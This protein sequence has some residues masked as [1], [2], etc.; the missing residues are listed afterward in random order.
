MKNDGLKRSVAAWAVLFIGLFLLAGC[1][2]NPALQ[3]DKTYQLTLM[4][5]NDQHGNFLPND[6][7]EYGLAAQE[8]LLDRYRGEVAAR[9]GYS[10]LLSAGDVNSGVPESSLQQAKP[11]FMGMRFLGY[12]AMVLGNHEF[13]VGREILRQQADW[14]GFP[15]LAANVF[16]KST[17]KHLFQDHIT[18]NFDGLN[19]VVFGLLTEDTLVVG[20]LEN[21]DNIEIRPAIETAAQIVP[22]LRK[23]AH[24]LIALTHMGYYPDG[25]YSINAPGDV[26]LARRVPGIDVIVGGHTHE[27]L[28]QPVVENGTLIVQAGEWGKYLGRLDLAYRNGNLNQINYRLTPVNLKKKVVK[29]GKKERV[30]IETKIPRDPGA[31]S[32]LAPFRESGRAELGRVI[33][34]VD[35]VLVGDRKIVRFKETNLANLI[36]R[37]IMEKT[38]ADVA[39]MNSGGIRDGIDAGDVTYRDVLTVLPFGNTLCTV[40]LNGAELYDYLAAVI[41]LPVDTGGFAQIAGVTARFENGIVSQLKINSEVLA[42]DR[43]YK[44]GINSFIASGAD[45][46]PRLKDHPSFYDTGYVCAN[47]VAEFVDKHSPLN[48]ADFAPQNKIVRR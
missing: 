20:N 27:A 47:V 12:D 2:T 3:A 26:T 43:V 25:N 30:F 31:V 40:K 11:D 36:N 22:H 42:K 13:D 34:H 4:H 6:Y 23:K 44:L 21:L 14:A 38:G 48:I 39:V 7:G 24:V 33:G 28:K 32:L 5:T 46:Y 37:A 35:G 19:V 8:T 18:F 10:L 1:A 41:S 17:G 16:D 9:G 45:G 15:F 29:D